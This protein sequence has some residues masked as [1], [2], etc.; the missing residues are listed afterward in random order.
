MGKVLKLRDSAPDRKKYNDRSR[1]ELPFPDV[2]AEDGY[3]CLF[4]PE[5]NCTTR[6]A[7]FVQV[8]SV[9]RNIDSGQV[10][11][12]LKFEYKG[13]LQT[14][15]VSRD[16]CLVTNRL[17][18]LSKY[19][20]DVMNTSTRVIAMHLRNQ[21]H[22]APLE[23]THEQVGW[24]IFENRL[25]FKHHRGVGFDSLYTGPLKLQPKGS[26]EKWLET[27]KRH[28]VGNSHLELALVLGLSAPMVGLIGKLIGIPNL[29]VHFAADS[30]RGKSTA[31]MLAVS[32]FGYPGEGENSLF[33][34]WLATDNAI[35][36]RLNGNFG[37][38]VVLDEASMS[39]AKDFSNL[40]YRFAGGVDKSRLNKDASLKKSGQWNTTVIS[41]GEFALSAKV[42]RNTG[43]RMRLLEFQ[44]V[45]WTKD[46]ASAD[47]IK[48]TILKNYGFAGVSMVQKLRAI[49]RKRLLALFGKRLSK[50]Y[51]AM[52]R[53]DTFSQ[54][55]ARKLA[56][57][58]LTA[59][60]AKDALGIT[61]NPEKIQ[62]ILIKNENNAV[63]ERDLGT[64][65]YDYFCQ[66][67][68]INK[69]KFE[70][71]H[72]EA[73]SPN[74]IYQNHSNLEWGDCEY[75]NDELRVYILPTIFERL[76]KEGQFEDTKVILKSWKQKG[77]LDCEKDRLT[78]KRKLNSS[79]PVPVYCIIIRELDQTVEAD[80]RPNP[81][82]IQHPKKERQSPPNHK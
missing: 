57:I 31:S 74:A 36:A 24:S 65:A 78:R 43:I 19:G 8:E 21:E 58:V 5:K 51:D 16:D 82:T 79:V 4:D 13:R 66:Q 68:N 10:T 47:A 56:L 40:I 71:R 41:N 42:N 27:V 52:E 61:L 1:D 35:V 53:K 49:G 59:E 6:V 72:W 7:R 15:E 23:L 9:F 73:R 33:S 14:L 67:F 75:K 2:I 26:H 64:N 34:T 29:L 3:I 25:V 69:G 77:L 30:T 38:P 50:V 18:E 46:A 12:R 17:L 60:V 32:S 11:L 70:R 62:E 39:N 76:M 20:L 44:N 55:I 54:R 22:L 63:V 48:N 37:V 80:V 81:A 28:V 45:T